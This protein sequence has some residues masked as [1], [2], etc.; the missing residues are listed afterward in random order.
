[1]SR[2]GHIKKYAA[3]QFYGKIESTA[4]STRCLRPQNAANNIQLSAIDS[5]SFSIKNRAQPLGFKCF[6]D[7][8][9]FVIIFNLS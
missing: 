8:M 6:R 2:S 3:R 4:Y 9:R 7:H 5:F 1:M